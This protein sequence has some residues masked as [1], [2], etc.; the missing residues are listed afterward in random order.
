M[1]KRSGPS[2]TTSDLSKRDVGALSFGSTL[3]TFRTER[4]LSQTDLA[5]QIS[6][7][8]AFISLLET[9]KR[10]PSSAL[11]EKLATALGFGPDSEERTA[12]RR[13]AG[14]ESTDISSAT[15]RITDLLGQRF[16]LG[17]A[18]RWTFHTDLRE[19]LEGWTAVF[20][21]RENFNQGYF[22][23]VADA[24]ESL[25]A[26]R[27][28][29]PTLRVNLLML[30][31]AAVSHLGDSLTA[32][33]DAKKV[34]SIIEK[35][36]VEPSAALV[37]PEL[38]DLR[39]MIATDRGRFDDGESFIR[40]SI[41]QYQKLIVSK[42]PAEGAGQLPSDE[43]SFLGLGAS[44]KRL[45]DI[46]L[47]RGEPEQAYSSNLVAES[48]L[49]RAGD[50]TE[51][52]HW[53]RRV[54]EQKAW[55]YSKTNEF[56]AAIALREE[57]RKSLKAA[58]DAYGLIRNLLFTGND[59]LSH[60][61]SILRS[62]FVTRGDNATGKHVTPPTATAA[63]AE[64]DQIT[65]E[66]LRNED[67]QQTLERAEEYY[68]KALE[69][70]GERGPLTMLGLCRRNLAVT[71][72]YKLLHMED[73]GKSAEEIQETRDDAQK[74]LSLALAIEQRIGNAQHIAAVYETLAQL[75]SDQKHFSNAYVFYRKGIGELDGV[76]LVPPD[77]TIKR[78]RDKLFS[79]ASEVAR[80]IETHG[81]DASGVFALGMVTPADDWQTRC[82]Q[83]VET[84]RNLIVSTGSTPASYSERA[85][86]WIKTIKNLES[87][88]GGR[89][90]LQN[91]LADGLTDRMFAGFTPKGAEMHAK[92]FAMIKQTVQAAQTLDQ[93]NRDFCCRNDVEKKLRST[94][95]TAELTRAQVETA[96][97]WLEKYPIGFWLESG[98]QAVPLG[99]FVKGSHILIEIPETLTHG[100]PDIDA[101][102]ISKSPLCYEIESAEGADTLRGMFD[103]FVNAA[104][105]QRNQHGPQNKD[106][107]EWLKK[108]HDSQMAT[109]GSHSTSGK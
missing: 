65:R 64:R 23:E 85:D 102:R 32:E 19:T 55:I 93:Q 17:E 95:G 92:R 24:C 10:R 53:L 58:Q 9:G 91:E 90:V 96:I 83:L 84:V 63:L 56:D 3:N 6:H 44:Y 33:Q 60:F 59:Y 98:D 29:S 11:T 106:T 41:S 76:L 94:D 27:H 70:L 1:S 21:A 109:V 100:L 30:E 107:L 101:A 104:A 69:D 62:R 15:Q 5:N 82:N 16:Q 40:Q 34:E 26:K 52:N 89:R 20:T 67:I 31:A 79:A 39:G 37:A 57:T 73:V 47:L 80:Q 42:K 68:R 99:F 74:Q 97:E 51:R 50:S 14:F 103:E 75:E 81:E 18:Q 43:I 78:Q 61:K 25:L 2:S 87:M 4:K 7:S 72:R 77:P 54:A 28:W 22:I 88:P 35:G 12:L 13:S 48:Y 49:M 8:A 45:A 36:E 46:V 66:A 86:E 71:L 105:E 108:L 38:T